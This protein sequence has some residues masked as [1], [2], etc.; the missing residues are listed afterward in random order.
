MR[1]FTHSISPGR[2]RLERRRSPIGTV[3]LEIRAYFAL[4]QYDQAIEW[5]RRA[6]VIDP[7]F[8]ADLVAPLAL[9][10]HETEVREALQRYLAAFQRTTQDD[11]GV[12]SVQ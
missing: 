12:E 7:S 1:I 6:V 9:S 10:G 5:A 2:S 4:K 11:C 3:R 8:G